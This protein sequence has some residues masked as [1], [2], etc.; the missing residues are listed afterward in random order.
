MQLFSL[1]ALG[2][3]HGFVCRSCRRA[4]GV[5]LPNSRRPLFSTTLSRSQRSR[6]KK[7]PA[8]GDTPSKL[9][10]FDEIMQEVITEVEE[11]DADPEAEQL[12]ARIDR[13][14]AELQFMRTGGIL[15]DSAFV[16]Q[17]SEEEK[18]EV[19]NVLKQRLLKR[20]DTP[21]PTSASTSSN[22]AMRRTSS[23]PPKVKTVAKREQKA[24]LNRLNGYL[25]QA[26]RRGPDPENRK[27]LWRWYSRCKQNIPTFRAQLTPDIWRTLWEA[28]S[29]RVP[30]NPDRAAHLKVL[31]EDMDAGGQEL[32]P[33]QRVEY[34]EAV[35]LE[36]EQSRAVT[37][38]ETSEKTLGQDRITANEYWELGIRMFAAQGKPGR[39]QDVARAFL[40][41]QGEPNARVLLPVISAW[42][43]A[44]GLAGFRHAWALYV[45]LKASL[46]PDMKMADYDAVCNSF[47]EAGKADLA[48]GVFKDMMLTREC[49]SGQDSA[50]LYQ[51]AMGTV[52]DIR[53]LTIEA[54]EINRV[55]LEAMAVLPR[56]FQQKFFYGSWIKKLLG[57]NEPDS[58]FLVVELMSKRGIQPDSK[59]LNGIMGAW[60]RLGDA[61]LCERAEKLSWELIE[62]RKAFAFQRR[63][64]TRGPPA[65]E[66][67]TERSTPTDTPFDA[68]FDT[69]AMLPKQHTPPA[70]LETFCIMINYYLQRDNHDKIRWLNRSIRLAEIR[71][72]SYFMNKL[73][74][75]QEESQGPRQVWETF[76]T[77]SAQHGA[78]R[79]DAETFAC[80]WTC[81]RR[82]IDRE[83]ID[84]HGRE[85]RPDDST[86][87]ES[88]VE[89]ESLRQ[90]R[91]ALDT[92]RESG[93]P[94]PRSLFATMINWF[95]ESDQTGQRQ[96]REDFSRSL[97]HLVLRCFFRAGIGDLK[98]GVVAMHA[99]KNRFGLYPDEQ[100]A[101][102][103]VLTLARAEERTKSA[104]YRMDMDPRVR[105]INQTL[106]GLAQ[107]RI[108]VLEGRGINLEEAQGH[109]RGEENLHLL[110][111][112]VRSVSPK[113]SSVEDVEH[114]LERA[115]WDMDVGGLPMGDHLS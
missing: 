101:K 13:L 12:K 44:G 62:R 87:D 91:E 82:R 6:P 32:S 24:Y 31:G 57:A 115:A 63:A 104:R 29:P 18:A 30:S 74:Y 51:K 77:W 41:K 76:S 33:A 67:I 99:M 110:S 71:P 89:S 81:V 73:L 97:Y 11:A 90:A 86:S 95:L 25:K 88:A 39:A 42:N 61:T 109:F 60:I 59:Y 50:A 64:G 35:F 80:L 68:P 37:E 52:V 114:S 85:T 55:S 40:S 45:R 10:P 66:D 16:S 23:T 69:S 94:S 14:E 48:L 98:G 100:T 2:Q 26:D 38:W 65:P 15:A 1:R 105:R 106:E 49:L 79:P 5:G 56:R 28:M 9:K 111:E 17:L 107:R 75:S 19:T 108:T 21:S 93:F 96:I 47:L 20:S 70:T 72:D 92:R 83:A 84:G 43:K 102:I 53:D 8:K 7:E 78:A 34:L 46:G 113:E 27:Q 22:Q 58:A 3:Q 4:L 36:G 103:I 54:S 112:L